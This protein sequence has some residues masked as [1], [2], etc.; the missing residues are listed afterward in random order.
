MGV[1][2][3]KD[4]KRG[5]RGNPLKRITIDVDSGLDEEVALVADSLNMSKGDVYSLMTD[6][7]LKGTEGLKEGLTQSRIFKTKIRVA[8]GLSAE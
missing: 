6:S 7:W 1:I 3:K 2:V 8:L 5:C 4:K